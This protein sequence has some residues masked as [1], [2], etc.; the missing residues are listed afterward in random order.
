[1]NNKWWKKWITTKWE[2]TLITPLFSRY[3]YC[4]FFSL[5]RL[6]YASGDSVT[7]AACRG[8]VMPS[9]WYNHG[10]YWFR[11]T[12]ITIKVNNFKI[13]I[14]PDYPTFPKHKYY[15]HFLLFSFFFFSS[16]RLLIKWMSA[17]QGLILTTILF[18]KHKSN[19]H[20]F[21]LSFSWFKIYY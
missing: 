16:S 6:L 20:L 1:M 9:F 2:F 15:L 4:L 19:F 17:K 13:R 3:K 18:L 7:I 12:F 21:S 11:L 14:Y 8:F 10:L 5:F